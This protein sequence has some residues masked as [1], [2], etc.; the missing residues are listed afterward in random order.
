MTVS[1][2]SEFVAAKSEP[3]SES[4]M[5]IS[6][7]AAAPLPK[8]ASNSPLGLK[9]PHS[10]KH[11]GRSDFG[12]SGLWSPRTLTAGLFPVAMDLDSPS[13]EINV[14]LMKKG[15]ELKMN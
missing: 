3:N 15:V 11:L 5:Q 4:G 1:A 12:L 9:W 10:V 14:L 2:F 7:K 13:V 6:Q 8:F